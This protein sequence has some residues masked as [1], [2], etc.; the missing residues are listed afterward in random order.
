MGE[1]GRWVQPPATTEANTPTRTK[2]FIAPSRSFLRRLIRL[3][4]GEESDKSG[5]MEQLCPTV[6]HFESAIEQ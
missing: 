5:I 2:V 1:E 3:L 4:A 6:R